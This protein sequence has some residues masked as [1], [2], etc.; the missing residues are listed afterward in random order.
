MCGLIDIEQMME[1]DDIA[2]K[3]DFFLKQTTRNKV[4]WENTF[5]V[6]PQVWDGSDCSRNPKIV[7]SFDFTGK[8][9]GCWYPTEIWFEFYIIKPE[10][11]NIFI[12]LG[13]PDSGEPTCQEICSEVNLTIGAKDYP[14]VVELSQAILSSTKEFM[15]P[16]FSPTWENLISPLRYRDTN[17]DGDLADTCV[18]IAKAKDY[19]QYIE[20]YKKRNQ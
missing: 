12:T 8:Y 6:P 17:W 7:T 13:G 1:Q 19:L 10:F 18:A 5:I 9:N 2:A 3:A 4:E 20:I 15:S 11:D 14:V 16:L